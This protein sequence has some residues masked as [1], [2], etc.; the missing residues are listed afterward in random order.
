MVSVVSGFD[1][2]A[3]K[4]VQLGAAWDGI[5]RSASTLWVTTPDRGR[6]GR[7]GLVPQVQMDGRICHDRDFEPFIAKASRFVCSTPVLFPRCI[8]GCF[9]LLTA[10][11]GQG[12]MGGVVGLALAL[13]HG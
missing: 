10:S 3:G 13:H 2:Q 7:A 5:L 1:K 4:Q 8:S 6:L 9:S 12:K 11:R